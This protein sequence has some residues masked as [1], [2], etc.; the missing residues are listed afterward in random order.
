[1]LMKDTQ[2]LIKLLERVSGKKVKLKE[3]NDYINSYQ[4]L[5]YRLSTV[6]DGEGDIQEEIS[7]F[8]WDNDGFWKS[9]SQVEF[10]NLVSKLELE[11]EDDNL[12]EQPVL[13]EGFE[14]SGLSVWMVWA[15][16]DGGYAKQGTHILC[17]KKDI[18]KLKPL[19]IKYFEKNMPASSSDRFPKPIELTFD[20]VASPKVYKKDK[21][22]GESL[23]EGTWAVPETFE[24]KEKAIEAIHEL[25]R[26]KSKYW[27]ILGDDDLYDGIDQAISC[28][29]KLLGE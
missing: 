13:K 10:E 5:I 16:R 21:T 12:L 22:V 11:F 8:L 3:N 27:D 24:E 25:N 29:Q 2:K 26:F 23:V 14:D 9:F 1:M 6:I 18:E 28:I 20:W 17:K 15:S 4:E 19:L 7:T